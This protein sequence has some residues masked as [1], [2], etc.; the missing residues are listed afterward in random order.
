MPVFNKDTNEKPTLDFY[1]IYLITTK[2]IVCI[3]IVNNI[4]NYYYC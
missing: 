1:F 3:N 2:D 4:E